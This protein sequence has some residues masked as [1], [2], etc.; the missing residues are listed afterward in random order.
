MTDQKTETKRD[1]ISQD[2][3][4]KSLKSHGERAAAELRVRE[5][6]KASVKSPAGEQ[7]D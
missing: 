6:E 3:L 2:P 7:A 5:L 1:E 4:V